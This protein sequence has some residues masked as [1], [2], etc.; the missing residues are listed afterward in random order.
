MR[1]VKTISRLTEPDRKPE[2]RLTLQKSCKK[3]GCYALLTHGNQQFCEEHAPK[4]RS[5]K[6]AQ[7]KREKQDSQPS[8]DLHIILRELQLEEASK[9]ERRDRF[10]F[11]TFRG[12]VDPIAASVLDPAMLAVTQRRLTR[13]ANRHFIRVTDL[14]PFVGPDG[15]LMI[16]LRDRR[17]PHG[18]RLRW[19]HLDPIKERIL[20]EEIPV[21]EEIAESWCEDNRRTKSRRVVGDQ[22][23]RRHKRA[24]SAVKAPK[25]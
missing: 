9:K 11:E 10:E 14:S 3:L 16:D 19:W 22:S 2:K 1:D 13:G 4:A 25:E 18:K 8:R 21:V 24:L 5:R 17:G 12:G 7:R 23:K 6:R 15:R 20:V